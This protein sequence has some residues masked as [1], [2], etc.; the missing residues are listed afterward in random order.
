LERTPHLEQVKLSKKGAVV[1][2]SVQ[3]NGA[4]NLAFEA[5][6]QDARWAGFAGRICRLVL[7][8]LAVSP[9][10]KTLKS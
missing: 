9:P 1:D 3:K 7:W 5:D 4:G 2:E 10:P 6:P 8:R